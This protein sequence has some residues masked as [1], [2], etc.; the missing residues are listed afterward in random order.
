MSRLA[1]ICDRRAAGRTTRKDAVL[2]WVRLAGTAAPAVANR[3]Q[4]GFPPPGSFVAPL[5]AQQVRHLFFVIRVFNSRRI[6]PERASQSNIVHRQ[7]Y[8]AN[9][10]ER[11][12][13]LHGFIVH[14]T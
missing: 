12:L 5:V 14:E 6:S 2:K 3:R 7:R 8:Q 10:L 9:A 1:D 13:N 4:A 11:H